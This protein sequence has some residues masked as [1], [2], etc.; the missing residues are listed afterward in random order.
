[1]HLRVYL[2]IWDWGQ[3]GKAS[4]DNKSIYHLPEG[5]RNESRWAELWQGWK[6][7]HVHPLLWGG[8][9]GPHRYSDAEYSGFSAG[10]HSIWSDPMYAVWHMLCDEC[11]F[12]S[13]GHLHYQYCYGPCFHTSHPNSAAVACGL[14]CIGTAQ[15]T[16]AHICLHC[17][18]LGERWGCCT[19]NRC[20]SKLH[21]TE[22]LF[23]ASHMG[24]SVPGI[25]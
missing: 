14:S 5:R 9:K 7:D 13:L 12:C 22:K 6:C 4:W 17:A 21:F 23:I 24:R 25:I 11:L 20:R 3:G 19:R 2:W 18:L 15:R 8:N 1:M 16:H 10:E